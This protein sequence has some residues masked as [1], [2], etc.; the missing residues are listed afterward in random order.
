[1]TP[2]ILVVDDEPN[3]RRSLAILLRR[4]GYRVTEAGS[5]ADAVG[6]LKDE[7][8]SEPF[9]LVIGDL[10]MEPLDG[11]DLLTLARRYCPQCRVMIVTAF[12]SHEARAE[13]LKR[14]AADFLEKPLDAGDL[15]IRIRRLLVGDAR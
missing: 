5:V 4:D 3:G 9:N 14:G 2:K 1:M 7:P 8:K 15:Q 10:R 13:C 12:G 6:R 11:V